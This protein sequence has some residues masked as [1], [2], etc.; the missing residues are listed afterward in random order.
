MLCDGRLAAGVVHNAV[1]GEVCTAAE[2]QGAW[3]GAERLAV[4]TIAE[5]AR[6]LIGTGIPFKRPEEIP[7]YLPQ[8]DRVIRRTAGVRRA[9]SAAL[10]LVD[11]ARGRFDAFWELSLAPWDVAAGLLLVREAGGLATDLQGTSAPVAHGPLVAGNPALHAWLLQ[12]LAAAASG[13]PAID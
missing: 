4:S 9:G 1:T 2:G 13:V 11:V 10:D 12:Q 5:P 3:C 7:T 6:A 8:L